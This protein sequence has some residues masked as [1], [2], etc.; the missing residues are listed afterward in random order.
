MSL[1][2]VFAAVGNYL[3]LLF[4]G[5]GDFLHAYIAPAF[6]SLAGAIFLFTGLILA[7]FLIG[8]TLWFA[9]Q[10]AK[11]FCSSVKV[12]FEDEPVFTIGT[13]IFTLFIVSAISLQLGTA[14]L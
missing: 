13:L 4:A 7:L 3:N 2:G 10:I 5:I 6:F 9:Y 12:N 1:E 14:L 8:F 11:N